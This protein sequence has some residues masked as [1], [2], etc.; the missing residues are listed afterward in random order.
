MHEWR[1][2]AICWL[3]NKNQDEF[4]DEPWASVWT[5]TVKQNGTMK[6]RELSV[7]KSAEKALVSLNIYEISSFYCN[8]V[9]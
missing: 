4:F 5:D 9:D 7:R 3:E 6:N 2:N 1:Y 8:D